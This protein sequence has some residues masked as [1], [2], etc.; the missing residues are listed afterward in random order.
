MKIDSNILKGWLQ[1]LFSCA[2]L[3]H[4]DASLVASN[5]IEAEMRGVYSHGL[6]LTRLYVDRIKSGGISSNYNITTRKDSNNILLL[7]GDGGSGQSL[8]TYAVEKGIKRA[9]KHGIA[10]VGLV[11]SNHV[12]M[13]ATYGLQIAGENMLGLIMT[14]SGP[15]VAV[16]G[17]KGKKMGNNALCFAIP[18]QKTPFIFDMATGVV[19]CG[20]I[21]YAHLQ[22][23]AL[24]S[25]WLCD[26]NGDNTTQPN[27]LDNG[28]FVLPFGKHKGFGI[29]L[30][31]DILTAILPG[32]I[33]SPKV[34][35]Q[36]W[37]LDKAT[38]ASQGFWIFNPEQLTS[39][40][41]LKY[42]LNEYFCELKRSTPLNDSNKIILPE[43]K[44]YSK[45]QQSLN[46]VFLSKQTLNHLSK[47]AAIVDYTPL[48]TRQVLQFA[49]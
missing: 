22:G 41:G 34:L 43:E 4:K 47:A 24:P 31:I 44:E 23:D 12:G 16:H 35:N 27:Y 36:R 14:N 49:N 40:E 48:Q 11:N 20:K 30:L 3:K 39:L 5:I 26:S 9:K 19:A 6:L 29:S 15:S 25:N 18:N 42:R 32:S 28:G 45:Y 37:N 13:L 8:A 33:P 10:W 21:R 2:G 17:G 7:D 46:G 38:G 1:G